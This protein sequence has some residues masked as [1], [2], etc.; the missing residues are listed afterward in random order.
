M[1]LGSLFDGS[2]EWRPIK[3]YE[4]EY[5][6]SEAGDVCSLRSKRKLKPATDKYGYLY[7]VLCVDGRRKTV[8]A[9][10]LVA[11]AFIENPLN[12][13]TVNHLNGV[14]NDNRVENLEW[15][16]EKEQIADA[17]KRDALPNM[18]KNTDYQAM[19]AKRNFGRRKAAVYLNGELLGI[20]SSLLDASKKQGINYSK[21]SECANGKRKTTGGKTV[22]FV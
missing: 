14:R 12:K 16:T 8:K 5:L 17:M 15:A 1:K 18:L 13:P 6:V 9:H 2:I 19:G 21:A 7:F 11:I 4:N 3:G 20:Y 10:R 22:C